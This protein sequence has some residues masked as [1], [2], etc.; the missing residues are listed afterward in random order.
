MKENER[1]KH[2]N[3]NGQQHASNGRKQMSCAE[4][5]A[6]LPGLMDVGSTD[7][8]T[9]HPHLAD[10]DKCSD[11]VRDLLYIADQA[12]LLLPMHDPSPRVWE[13]IKTSL[14]K[15]GYVSKEEQSSKEK[16]GSDKQL[17][18]TMTNIAIAVA[19]SAAMLLAWL[20]Y[21]AGN[22]STA[23]AQPAA[24]TSSQAHR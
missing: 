21:P 20:S 3:D 22:H 12:K 16:P 13:G 7:K 2:K 8:I 6:E 14:Q 24:P 23:A 15:E 9:N 18:K 11:L 19:L 1:E 17:R 4:F 5:Q 10:C